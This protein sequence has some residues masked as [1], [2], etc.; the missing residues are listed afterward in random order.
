MQKLC[1]VRKKWHC[2]KV[3]KTRSKQLPM[4]VYKFQFISSREVE[5]HPDYIV[6]TPGCKIMEMN[7]FDKSV[8]KFLKTGKPVKCVP[9]M[10]KRSNLVHTNTCNVH[11]MKN[12]TKNNFL[13]IFI[14]NFVV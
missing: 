1:S 2:Y 6:Y 5:S 4:Y 10:F 12:K 9:R 13:A 3:K 8:K 7:P 14:I 11:L